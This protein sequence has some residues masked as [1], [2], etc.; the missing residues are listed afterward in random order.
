[1]LARRWSYRALAGWLILVAVLLV[2]WWTAPSLTPPPG[3]EDSAGVELLE[4][5]VARVS[6][7][8]TAAPDSSPRRIVHLEVLSGIAAG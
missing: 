5:R 6:T 7:A 8:P 1:M 2:L 4:A 3:A